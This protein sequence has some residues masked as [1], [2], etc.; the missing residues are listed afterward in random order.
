MGLINV[1]SWAL[2]SLALIVTALPALAADYPVPQEGDWLVRDFRFH[3]GDVL[4]ELR[5]HDTTV[6]PTGEPV[7]ILHGTTGSGAGM[8]RPAFAGE[9]FGPGQP[10][11]ASRYYI[12]LSDA[13]GTGQSSKLLN[14]YDRS[15]AGPWYALFTRPVCGTSIAVGPKSPYGDNMITIDGRSYL[16][17][18]GEFV[19]F[20]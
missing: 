17:K 13:I 11:D 3:T 7:L 6:S 5:L 16:D 14:V 8:L 12:I 2:S 18:A 1:L 19:P 10:L 4:P 15:R 9:L 20:K